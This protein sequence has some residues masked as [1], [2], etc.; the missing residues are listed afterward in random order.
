MI[1]YSEDWL[2]TLVFQWRGSVYYRACVFAIP[3]ALLAHICTWLDEWDENLRDTLGLKYLSQSLLWSATTAVLTML[4]SFRTNR[5]MARFWEGTGLLH[6]MR[7]EWF[8]SISCCVTFS[9][10]AVKDKRAEVMRFRHTIVRLMSL[11][12]GSALEEIAGHNGD[13]VET[14]D[15]FG[16]DN[17]TLQ[18]LKDCKFVHK[19]NRVEVLLHLTQSI[20]TKSLEDGILKIPPPI[21]SRV[22]QTLSRG[23]VNLLNA[24]KIADTRFPFPYAQLITL[25][26]FLHTLLT[27]LFISSIVPSRVWAPILTFVPI[28]SFFAVNFIGVELENPFGSDDN[29]LPLD[30][31]QGEMNKCLMMLLHEGADLMADIS[32]SRCIMDYKTLASTLTHHGSHA[33]NE[34]AHAFE[35]K[36]PRI[37]EFCPSDFFEDPPPDFNDP[38]P[39][40]G[41]QRQVSFDSQTPLPPPEKKAEGPPAISIPAVSLTMKN[42]KT[43]PKALTSDPLLDENSFPFLKKLV[44]TQVRELSRSI[45]ALNDFSNALPGVIDAMLATKSLDGS[46]LGSRTGTASRDAAGVQRSSGEAASAGRSNENQAGAPHLQFALV[47]SS[48]LQQRMP[49]RELTARSYG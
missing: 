13:E 42:D 46:P 26:L 41:A 21:L 1:D 49:D 8:D 7:G 23:F 47:G 48:P 22:Y 3:C 4:L 45:Q 29:D 39:K 24:K 27:P 18:H 44:E 30:H 35:V 12:H 10:G 2:V 17:D 32:T 15:P 38:T 28:F 9:V 25:L 16:L 5:A 20:I 33:D 11:C 6:Q 31:F 14:I 37:S 43:E 19:F 36:V 34:G 40:A